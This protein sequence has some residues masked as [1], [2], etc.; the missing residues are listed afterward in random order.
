MKGVPSRLSLR[1]KTSSRDSNA[2]QENADAAGLATASTTRTTRETLSDKQTPSTKKTPATVTAKDASAS[3][4]RKWKSRTGGDE[5]EAETTDEDNEVLKDQ[6]NEGELIDEEEIEQDGEVGKDGQLPDLYKIGGAHD[7][8]PREI[9]KSRNKT[10][11]IVS[12]A[13]LETFERLAKKESFLESAAAA[14]FIKIMGALPKVMLDKDLTAVTVP[15]NG[16]LAGRM[17]PGA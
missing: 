10:L 5:D 12:G 16:L 1:S 7:K 15:F 14:A 4:S 13:Y 11:E 17:A 9:A 2:E 6:V 3:A 8:Q